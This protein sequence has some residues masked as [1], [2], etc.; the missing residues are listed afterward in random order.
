VSEAER[1]NLR[2]IGLGIHMDV[3]AI[4]PEARRNEGALLMLD[5]LGIDRKPEK[6]RLPCRDRSRLVRS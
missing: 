1:V 5:V 4:D 6:F 3:P 2:V